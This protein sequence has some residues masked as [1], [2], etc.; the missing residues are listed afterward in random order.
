MPAVKIQP[1]ADRA[2]RHDAVGALR[3]HRS[4]DERSDDGPN[5]NTGERPA[6]LAAAR[7]GIKMVQRH[8][9]EEKQKRRETSTSKRQKQNEG[10]Q[11]R[12]TVNAVVI[13]II[14]S[15]R[16]KDHS[17]PEKQRRP[18]AGAAASARPLPLKSAG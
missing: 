3:T 12:M 10:G 1:I 11:V 4:N 17:I 5:N 6:C 15:H 2:S 16:T 8:A 7:W 13:R 18:A 9:K 14:A